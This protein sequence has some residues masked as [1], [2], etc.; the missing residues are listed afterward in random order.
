MIQAARF[1]GVP[2]WEY[3]ALLFGEPVEVFRTPA[4]MVIWTDWAGIVNA[5]EAA[6]SEPPT[7]SEETF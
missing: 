2:A 6:L 5:V 1:Y 4:A 7:H 3:A